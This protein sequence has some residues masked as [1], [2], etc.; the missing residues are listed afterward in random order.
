MTPEQRYMFDLT[1][2]LLVDNVLSPNELKTCQDATQRYINTPDEDLPAG[3]GR[4]G[5]RHLHAF[6]FDECLAKLPLHP[7][8][9]PIV[10]EL[11]NDKPRLCS[12]TM[13]AD[14]PGREGGGLHCARDDFGWEATRYEVREG[15]IYSNDFVV[16][17]YL[18]DVYPGDGGLIVLPGS[19]KSNFDRPR[20]LFADVVDG[21]GRA[22]PGAVTGELPPAVVNVTPK[23]GDMVV[24]PESVTHGILPWKPKDRIRRILQLR[25]RPQHQ[26]GG[27]GVPDEVA[28]RLTPEIQELLETAHYT[29]VKEIAKPGRIAA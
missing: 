21:H 22:H 18:D 28:K 1:G 16:F 29:H 15:R 4:D 8:I 13:T 17:P 3:F 12:G 5:I 26:S 2:Y 11:T 23:A 10:M 25:F 19:H 20:T 27:I 24:M 14:E 7:G 6:A 9:W